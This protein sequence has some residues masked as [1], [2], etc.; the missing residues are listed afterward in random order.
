MTIEQ[1]IEIYNQC[2][3]NEAIKKYEEARHV[4]LEESNNRKPKKV[5]YAS[6]KKNDY[7]LELPYE[8]IRFTIEGV[9]K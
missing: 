4:I 1:A 6:S 9:K 3:N 7:Y 5:L 2:F 8:D